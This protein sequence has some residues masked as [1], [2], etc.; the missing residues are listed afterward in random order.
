MFNIDFNKQAELNLPVEKRQPIMLSV[1][2]WCM[3][4]CKDIH[5]QLINLFNNTS[6]YLDFNGQ[7]IYM[8]HVLN[9]KFDPG[10]RGI[11]I[12]NITDKTFQFLYNKSE[13]KDIRYVY[14]KSEGK[15]PTYFK[16]K[17]ENY[18]KFDFVVY[19]PLNAYSAVDEKQIKALVNKYKYAGKN[20]KIET[21]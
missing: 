8:E 6:Y 20:Y 17:V 14:N 5:A 7:T 21:Y 18:S 11:Y 10:N 13:N 16:N 9:D 15:A 3:K 19:V 12:D 1:V 2:Y 4:G